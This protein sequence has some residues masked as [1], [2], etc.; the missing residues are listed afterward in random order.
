MLKGFV[1][2][3][4]AGMGL[5]EPE[6]GGRNVS[7][8]DAVVEGSIQTG[9]QVSYELYPGGGEPEASRVVPR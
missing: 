9:Q 3:Y 5:I 1:K 8:V 4:A 6:S 7:F 2:S